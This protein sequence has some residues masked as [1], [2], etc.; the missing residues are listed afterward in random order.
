MLFWYEISY[1]IALCTGL[2]DQFEALELHSQ[3]DPISTCKVTS[4]GG[5]L[6]IAGTG[7]ELV[8][9]EGAIP[10]GKIIEIKL[11]LPLDRDPPP[12]DDGHLLISPIVKCD[13]EPSGFRFLKAAELTLPSYADKVDPRDVTLWTKSSLPGKGA[14]NRYFN[15]H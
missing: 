3:K 6:C 1:H 14:L 4:K 2:L 13:C 12:L 8:V 5:K 15:N 10:H 7:I 9:P 11:S